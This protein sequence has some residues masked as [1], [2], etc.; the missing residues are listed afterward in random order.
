MTGTPAPPRPSSSGARWHGTPWA[1]LPVR[2]ASPADPPAHPTASRLGC[3]CHCTALQ[4]PADVCPLQVRGLWRGRSLREHSRQL[5]SLQ[6]VPPVSLCL[7]AARRTPPARSCDG[8]S[9][10]QCSGC[11][12]CLTC[13]AC[14]P[15]CVRACPATGSR[16]ATDCTAPSHMDRLVRPSA[17]PGCLAGQVAMCG[18]G[19]SGDLHGLGRHPLQDNGRHLLRRCPPPL[20][21]AQLGS[22]QTYGRER[23]RSASDACCLLSTSSPGAQTACRAAGL[24]HPTSVSGFQVSS[25]RAAAVGLRLRAA[26]RPETCTQA[27]L[28]NFNRSEN[29]P[30]PALYTTPGL[31]FTC[32][33]LLWTDNPCQGEFAAVSGPPPWCQHLWG[34]PR[35]AH[36]GPCTSCGSSGRR[37]AVRTSVQVHHQQPVPVLDPGVRRRAAARLTRCRLLRRGCWT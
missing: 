19:V 25:A 4:A 30:D 8:R 33:C 18:A 10:W 16:P 24:I 11:S 26:L 6:G 17:A 7:H 27:D 23:T 5:P 2:A 15:L 3:P 28:A 9:A 34:C 12:A 37:T 22:H 35:P 21:P 20:R 1:G 14:K 13:E 32:N 29:Y 36:Q 31:N